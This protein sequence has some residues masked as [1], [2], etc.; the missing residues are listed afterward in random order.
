MR[1]I[2]IENWKATVPEKDDSGNIVGSKEVEE[3]LLMAINLLIANK[4]P[5][6]MPKGLEKFRLFN[7]LGKAFDKAERTKVLELEEG[8]YSFLK[9]T[10][11]KD[12]PSQWGLSENFSKAVEA[13]L[14]AK[15]EK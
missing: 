10:I 9:E 7:R 13:F 12:I 14:D 5:E 1:R 4:K 11:E 3:N 15:E 8:D 6:E 2:K